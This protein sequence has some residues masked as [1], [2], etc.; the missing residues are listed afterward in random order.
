MSE[1]CYKLA[2]LGLTQ[3]AALDLMRGRAVVV[4]APRWVP[5]AMCEAAHVIAESG[6][7]EWPD[8]CWLAYQQMVSASP[9][10]MAH[11]PQMP[12]TPAS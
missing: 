8:I 2:E 3:Q 7:L 5:R 1:R 9:Y 12:A 4:P 6:E 11:V 10:G